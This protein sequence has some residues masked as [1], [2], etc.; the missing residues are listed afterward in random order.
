M[1]KKI[2]IEVEMTR[3][4]IA[5]LMEASG[6]AGCSAAEVLE[7]FTADLTHSDRSNGSDEREAAY[8]YFDRAIYGEMNYVPSHRSWLRHILIRDGFY[9]S[10]EWCVRDIIAKVD[11]L[12]GEKAD[13]EEETDKEERKELAECIAEDEKELQAEIDEYLRL[14]GKKA[15]E[16]NF[17]EEFKEICEWMR[18]YDRLVPPKE[19]AEDEQQ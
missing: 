4:E 12:N 8:A 14:S 3:E 2:K 9:G 17:D 13:L 1:E 15:S 11:V 16:F 19:E 6:A 7:K 10:G 18:E 5:N